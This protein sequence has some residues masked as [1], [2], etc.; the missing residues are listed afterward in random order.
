MII[1][2]KLYAH[3]DRDS[4]YDLIRTEAESIGFELTEKAERAFAYVGYEI[5]FD[6]EID[7][8]TGVCHALTV[9]GVEL[10]EPLEL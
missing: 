4:N 8:E 5:S 6:V 10:P 3:R 9:N 1:K 2:T 7:L